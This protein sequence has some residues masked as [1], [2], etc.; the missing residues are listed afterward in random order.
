MLLQ[1][2]A[3]SNDGGLLSGVPSVEVLET[4]MGGC[5]AVSLD[6]ADILA[7]NFFMGASLFLFSVALLTFL[8]LGL[9]SG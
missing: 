5:V 9:V 6:L 8:T 2:G 1:I 7:L 4:V 3:S